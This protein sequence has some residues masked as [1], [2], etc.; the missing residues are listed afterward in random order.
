MGSFVSDRLWP[1]LSSSGGLRTHVPGPRV[2]APRQACVTA[3]LQKRLRHCQNLLHRLCCHRRSHSEQPCPSL[4]NNLKITC[5]EFDTNSAPAPTSTCGAVIC[6]WFS[7]EE[8]MQVTE[9]A[10]V[11]QPVE[12]R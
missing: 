9:G 5:A 7:S 8:D 4:Q 11:Q 10:H 3:D 6:N 1:H 12:Q 2:H